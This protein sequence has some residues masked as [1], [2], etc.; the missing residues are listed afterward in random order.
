MLQFPDVETNP[1][2]R[3]PAPTVC[4]LLCTVCSNVRGLV[5]NLSYLTVASSQYNILL[6]SETLV[7][8]CWFPDLVALSCA[9]E[10]CLGPKGWLHM[11]AMDMEHFANPSLSVVV[12][13]CCFFLV[14]GVR[15]NFYVFSLYRNPDLVDWIFHCLPTSMAAVQTEDVLASFLFVGDLS[16][17]HQEWLGFYNHKSS[18]FCS[19]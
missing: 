3:Q 17:H 16:G 4:R 1:A 10:G 11:Y 5:G 9:G 6:C 13:K 2:L 14:C 8:D 12:A 15:Q 19:L 7:S 18:R